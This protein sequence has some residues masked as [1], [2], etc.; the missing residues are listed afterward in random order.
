M[1]DLFPDATALEAT[2]KPA[3]FSKEQLELLAENLR[4]IKLKCDELDRKAWRSLR[5]FYLTD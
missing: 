3:V 5:D 1:R 4:D 2:A